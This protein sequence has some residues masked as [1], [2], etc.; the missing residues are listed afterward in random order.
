[1]ARLNQALA[2]LALAALVPAGAWAAGQAT[3]KA[4]A[5]TVRVAWDDA[6]HLRVDMPGDD[7]AL[8]SRDGQV[9]MVTQEGGQPVVMEVGSMMNAF[10]AMLGQDDHLLDARISDLK[11]TGQSETHAGIR[12]QVY[13][14]RLSEGKGQARDIELVL[15]DH[16][17]V[18]ELTGAYMDLVQALMGADRVGALK[19]QLPAGRRGFLRMD[20]EITLESISAKAPPAD[21]FTLP[22][23]PTSMADLFK[24]MADQLQQLQQMQK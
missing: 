11:P 21:A 8:I 16:A 10:T 4:D 9:Y 3:L 15:T 2:T 6:G 23:P 19:S 20:S 18:N 14:G 1:M 17:L 13:V 7:G 12:G 24:G 22:A 5:D